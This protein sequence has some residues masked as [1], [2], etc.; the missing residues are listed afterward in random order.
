MTWRSL[1]QWFGNLL[2]CEWWDYLWLNEGFASYFQLLATED[3]YPHWKIVRILSPPPPLSLPQSFP[4]LLSLCSCLC[5]RA[6]VLV[7]T[8]VNMTWKFPYRLPPDGKNES[9]RLLLHDENRFSASR[10]LLPWPPNAESQPGD[11]CRNHESL[12]PLHLC[13]GES[14]DFSTSVSLSSHLSLSLCAQGLS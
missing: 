4:S 12:R 2:T 11:T 7:C 14:L 6:C 9:G 3:L 8:C 13:Q 5:A 1:C 10:L